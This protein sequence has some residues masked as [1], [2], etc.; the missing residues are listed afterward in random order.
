[1]IVRWTSP[2]VYEMYVFLAFDGSGAERVRTF[3]KRFEFKPAF[4]PIHATYTDATD[5]GTQF[6]NNAE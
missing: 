6:T 1:M 3:R 5:S 2:V 4:I